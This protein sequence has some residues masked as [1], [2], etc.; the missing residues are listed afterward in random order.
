MDPRRK[1]PVQDHYTIL[2]LTT[3]CTPADIKTAYR[4]LA[5]ILHP[6]KKPNDPNA[7]A[8]FQKLQEAHEVLSYWHAP[9]NEC[10]R[11]SMEN[12]KQQQA[13]STWGPDAQEKRREREREEESQSQRWR[14]DYKRQSQF[15]SQQPR[16]AK[17]EHEEVSFHFH[18]QFRPH[19]TQYHTTLKT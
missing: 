1:R 17:E 6:D 16:M 19:P 14:E 5:L 4:R 10:E 2:G 3:T 8:K 7:T 15:Q 13:Q 12:E 18:F 9:E 11:K